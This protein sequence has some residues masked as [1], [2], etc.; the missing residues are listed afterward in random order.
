MKIQVS[1]GASLRERPPGTKRI[2]FQKGGFPIIGS[3]LHPF[4]PN[5]T[6]WKLYWEIQD[7]G[8]N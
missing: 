7:I 2:N 3:S 4:L 6:Q 8:K 5:S 1:G